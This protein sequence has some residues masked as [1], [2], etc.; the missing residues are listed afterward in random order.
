MIEPYYVLETKRKFQ[1]EK[2]VGRKCQLRTKQKTNHRL[3]IV[4]SSFSVVF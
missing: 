4:E 1:I 2:F 3:N